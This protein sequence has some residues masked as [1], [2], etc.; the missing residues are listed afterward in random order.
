[1]LDCVSRSSLKMALSTP[2]PYCHCATLL[3]DWL[4]TFE[5]NQMLGASCSLWLGSKPE[6]EMI[7]Q[8]NIVYPKIQLITNTGRHIHM[9]LLWMMTTPIQIPFMFITTTWWPWTYVICI[10]KYEYRYEYFQICI[11]NI[12]WLR[13]LQYLVK[14]TEIKDA[15]RFTHRGI[16]FDTSRH[17]I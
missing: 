6:Q 4:M 12:K 14:G 5:S 10:Y 13:Y 15:P 3:T 8:S 11:K 17:F 9:L 16:L 7:P 2:P 1:M